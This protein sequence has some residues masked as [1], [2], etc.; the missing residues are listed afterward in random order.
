MMVGI[1]RNPKNS[2]GN[3][4]GPYIRVLGTLCFGAPFLP[5]VRLLA[6]CRIWG[7]GFKDLRTEVSFP[8]LTRALDRNP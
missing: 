1:M 8:A 2:T 5:A 6:L 7:L 4:L 3:Y